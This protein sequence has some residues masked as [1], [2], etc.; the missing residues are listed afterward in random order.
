M[1]NV[2][3]VDFSGREPVLPAGTHPLPYV[4]VGMVLH[5]G[6]PEIL[7][8]VSDIFDSGNDTTCVLRMVGMTRMTTS[9][10][11]KD[12]RAEWTLAEPFD[13]NGCD[14]CGCTSVPCGCEAEDG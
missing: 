2:I 1:S 13:P 6:Q 12:V 10:Y 7:W 8:R 4:Q 11:S 5:C 3:N 9:R 14:E